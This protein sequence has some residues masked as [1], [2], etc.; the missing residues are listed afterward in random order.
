M[1]GH[2]IH[3]DHLSKDYGPV[4][5]VSDLTFTVLPG[6]VTGFLGP[7]GA[8][9]TTT[10]QIL[11]NLVRPS[12]GSAT[13]D[14]SLY[15]QIPNPMHEVGAHLS[16]DAFHP[17]RTGRD[18]LKVMAAGSGLT[19]S[20]ILALLELVGLS[21]DAD[22]RVGG[23]SLGMRQRL[24]LATALLGDPSVLIL[25]EPANGLDPEGIS[26]LRTFLR[27]QADQG[28]TV[29]LSSHLLNEVQQ[30]ADD[31]VIINRGKLVT[32]GGVHA[33]EQAGGTVVLAD[34]LQRD[35]LVRA[36]TIANL[37]VADHPGSPL[38][39]AGTNARDV[40]NIALVTGIPLTHLSEET[41][42]LEALFLSMVGGAR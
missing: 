30:M 8:G 22:R 3:I 23:Y 20:R 9:K 29:F 17:G 25:D 4:A 39:I 13:F 41:T 7:N 31:I 11:L 24:G 28:R 21:N 10:L 32:T 16:P 37:P 27:G 42:G 35:E 18:H 12:S 5:A 19:P 15:R 14:G 1:Q 38:R 26:W 6:K 40:G 2:T 34:S 36:L 33:L